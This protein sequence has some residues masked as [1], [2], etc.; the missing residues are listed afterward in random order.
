[1][2]SMN[3]HQSRRGGAAAICVGALVVV[4]AAGLVGLALVRALGGESETTAP[5]PGDAPSIASEADISRLLESVQVYVTS[6]QRSKAHAILESSV[7]QY[8]DDQDLRLAYGLL[9]MQDERWEDAFT[10]YDAAAL[11]GPISAQE[12]F[13]AG[14]LASTAGRYEDAARHYNFAQ[15]A[16]A[17][18]ADYPLYLAQTQLKIGLKDEAM[19]SLVRASVLDDSNALVWG[20]MASVALSENKVH[21]A[22]QHIAR[23]RELDPASRDWRL[24]QARAMKRAGKIEDAIGVLL[25]LGDELLTDDEALRTMGECHAMLGE[26][27]EALELYEQAMAR[28]PGSA[29]LV[30]EGAIWAERAGRPERALELARQAAAMGHERASALAERLEVVVKADG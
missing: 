19:A 5:D 14:T 9:L 7:G 17:S 25:G 21:M 27:G 29:A 10:Q 3:T 30:Y 18:N 13:T 24:I 8:P 15:R 1:M 6:G 12:Y 23:A 2:T 4:L 26:A 16:D 22:M 28:R 20:S 11:A